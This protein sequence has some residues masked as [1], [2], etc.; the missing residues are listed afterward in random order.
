MKRTILSLLVAI[1]AIAHT[2]D[3]C[4]TAVI[5]GKATPDGRSII[6]K[7]RDTDD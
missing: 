5:S 3:A 1:F 2:A 7:V 6:W 4:T